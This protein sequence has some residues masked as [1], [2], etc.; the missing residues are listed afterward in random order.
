MNP[1]TRYT[2]AFLAGRLAQADSQALSISGPEGN[3]YFSGEVTPSYINVSESSAGTITGSGNNNYFSRISA[4]SQAED[5]ELK[6]SG[7][8]FEGRADSESFKGRVSGSEIK[9][10]SG[11]NYRLQ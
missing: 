2:I 10:D 7:T 11:E 5:F 4:S 1:I 9:F 8:S 3:K 6:V